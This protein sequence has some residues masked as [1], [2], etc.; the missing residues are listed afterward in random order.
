MLLPIIFP[1]PT[2]L[3]PL[4]IAIIEVINSGREVPI[5]ITVNPISFSDKPNSDAIITALSTVS[6]APIYN[7]TIPIPINPKYFT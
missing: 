7:T 2:S 1:I 4:R 3:W 5:A 6:I